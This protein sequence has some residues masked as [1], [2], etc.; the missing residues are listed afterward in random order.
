MYVTSYLVV[1]QS[2]QLFISAK[3]LQNMMVEQ[4]KIVTNLP[5]G[6]LICKQVMVSE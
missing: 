2:K 1:K 3:R 5:D 4:R 6:V